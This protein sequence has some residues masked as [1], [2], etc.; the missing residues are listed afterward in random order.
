MQ[1]SARLQAGERE[2]REDLRDPARL[3]LAEQTVGRR[4]GRVPFSA[5]EQVCAST[6]TRR[7]HPSTVRLSSSPTLCG[8]PG[9]VANTRRTFRT[10]TAGRRRRGV[11]QASTGYVGSMARERK[12]QRR[13]PVPG[14]G[15]PVPEHAST[16]DGQQALRLHSGISVVA[17]VL[18]AFV[19]V[20]F[21]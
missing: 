7:S 4:L 18:C 19:A 2:Q 1:A 10:T 17:F 6:R 11:Q 12:T 9:L 5:V 20:V 8:M 21:L 15:G 14:F 13:H 16:R 3:G